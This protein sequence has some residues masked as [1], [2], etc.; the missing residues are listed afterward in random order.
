MHE[1]MCFWNLRFQ[2]IGDIM[3]CNITKM[4][5]SAKPDPKFNCFSSPWKS[6]YF[7]KKTTAKMKTSV[8]KVRKR[9]LLK[10]LCTASTA[11]RNI[12]VSASSANHPILR[13]WYDT[14]LPWV[15]ITCFS[16]SIEV[17]HSARYL[18]NSYLF[19]LT[20]RNSLQFRGACWQALNVAIHQNHACL[21]S[22]LSNYS[23]GSHPTQYSFEWRG[24]VAL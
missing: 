24:K 7:S 21:E 22:W 15:E 16:A 6:S 14:C 11:W 5:T 2:L 13:D 3:G 1:K 8:S 4:C 10:P 20:R 12:L 17:T 23:L 19:W 9:I 18:N